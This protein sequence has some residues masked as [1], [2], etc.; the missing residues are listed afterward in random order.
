M[1]SITKKCNRCGEEKTVDCFYK[2]PK[3]RHGVRSTCKMC[4]DKYTEEYYYRTHARRLEKHRE[5]REENRD[6]LRERG[7]LFHANHPERGIKRVFI[8]QN[9]EENKEKVRKAKNKWKK[10]HPE[11]VIEHDRNRRAKEKFGGGKITANEWLEL[12]E[13]AG[14]KC[15][16]CGSTEKLTLDHVIPLARGGKHHI[17]NAQVLCMPCN[18]KKGTKTEDYR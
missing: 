1:N 12:L 18:G 2:H 15:M 10:N 16:K 13:Q 4:S 5:Y 11:K 8:W 3:G 9:K 6:K 7:R 17:S 14:H